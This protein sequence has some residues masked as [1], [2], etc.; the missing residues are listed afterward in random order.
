[1]STERSSNDEEARKSRPKPLFGV[2]VNPYV[3]E[4]EKAF[5]I[6]TLADEL[7]MDI[8]GIQ[9]HPYNGRFL[10]TWTLLTALADSTRNIRFMTNVADLPLRPPSMLAKAAA[11]LDLI[12]KGRVELGIGAG[13]FWEAIESY[14][15]P[16][17]NPKESVYAL[18]EAIQV[19]RL[20]WDLQ[21]SGKRVSFDGKYYTLKD[22]RVG[23]RPY[24][25]IGIWIGAMGARMLR[26]TGRSGDG[27]SVSLSYVPVA[28]ISA[29]QKI[30]D[31]AARSCG[32]APSSIR[33]NLNFSGII[34]NNS[35]SK[36]SEPAEQARIDDE[37]SIK[38]SVTAW[39]NTL[40]S[41]YRN[42]G[43][44]SFNFWPASGEEIKNLRLFA[45]EVVPRVREIL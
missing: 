28:E 20:V 22:A 10:D 25:R 33:R 2:N 36:S 40:V 1:M 21:G 23:P 12:T 39:V 32:R 13:A 35:S 7:G 42:L 5:K 41:F 8:I 26:L 24:H 30:I 18:E 9:D 38:G 6:A 11:T 43:V 44:D 4:L 29:K 16:A 17:R 27:W 15:G 14:G 31:E 45:E 37:G 19:I 3:T 34:E